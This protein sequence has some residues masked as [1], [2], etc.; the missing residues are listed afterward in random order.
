MFKM[1]KFALEVFRRYPQNAIFYIPVRLD[2]CKIP[3]EELKSIHHVDLF[4]EWDDG[5]SAILHAP[6]REKFDMTSAALKNQQQIEMPKAKESEDGTKSTEK[7]SLA[8]T[9]IMDALGYYG[10]GDYTNALSCLDKVL[11]IRS[12]VDQIA[13]TIVFHPLL[14]FL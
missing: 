1:S 6:N 13:F 9:T 10:N 5:F 14:F 3:Y 7:T 2:D 11:K 12:V 4:P 8:D